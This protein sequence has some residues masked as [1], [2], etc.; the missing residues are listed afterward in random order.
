MKLP[1]PCAPFERL[2]VRGESITI[3]VSAKRL[4]IPTDNQLT[5]PSFNQWTESA[6]RC[7]LTETPC[8]GLKNSIVQDTFPGSL[9]IDGD[10][11]YLRNIERTYTGKSI[12]AG[13]L[14][15]TGDIEDTGTTGLEF[16]TADG[17]VFRTWDGV[18]FLLNSPSTIV[19]KFN[20]INLSS[21]SKICTVYIVCPDSISE[22]KLYNISSIYNESISFTQVSVNKYS[23]SRELDSYYEES[24]Q[25]M[26]TYNNLSFTQSFSNGADDAI[27][28]HN[29][30][31]PWIALTTSIGSDIDFFLFSDRPKQLSYT[32]NADGIITNITLYPGNG[33]ISHG[34]LTYQDLLVDSNYDKIP[35]CININ[36]PHNLIMG[37]WHPSINPDGYQPIW[38]YLTHIICGSWHPDSN[39]IIT[40]HVAYNLSYINKIKTL[41]GDKPIKM[42]LS[43]GMWTPVIDNIF[44]NHARDFANELLTLLQTYSADGICLD[45][46]FPTPINSINGES[47]ILLYTELLHIIRDALNAV[48]PNYE[49]S[50]CIDTRAPTSLDSDY[51]EYLN[52]V[53]LMGYDS[54]SGHSGPNA[55]FQSIYHYY[56]VIDSIDSALNYYPRDKL[57]FCVAWYGYKFTTASNDPYSPTLSKTSVFASTAL[58]ESEIYGRIWDA[59]SQTPWYEY[60]SGSNWEQVWYDDAESLGIKYDY[61]RTKNLAG[62]GIF[63]LGLEGNTNS[64]IW[65]AT[66]QNNTG[67]LSRFLQS[68]GMNK[69]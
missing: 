66:S 22:L 28:L 58:R 42:I 40:Y 49:L 39:G 69:T 11:C 2:D 43:V 47:N 30:S 65:K 31:G 37:F 23:F 36:T 46:E 59:D 19:V 24:L 16:A 15:E 29:M 14:F 56:N 45:I 27:G 48:N 61:I 44:A 1:K 25:L 33:S 10:G 21:D 17:V 68:Y 4:V 7:N 9:S 18:P 57:I 6:T 41:L 50:I 51:A 64:E 3:D 20:I 52:Y 35:D 53:L 60:T 12:G 55:P 34:R 67:S 63:S 32:Q 5:L 13:K 26:I 8:G 54:S 38:N 62:I